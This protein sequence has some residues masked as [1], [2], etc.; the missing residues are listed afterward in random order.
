MIRMPT[1][2]MHRSIRRASGFTLIELAIA[3]AVALFLIGGLLTILQNVRSTQTN[4]TGLAQLQ[5]NQRMAMTLI[6]NVVQSAGYF[7]D[8][9]NYTAT[10]AMPAIGTPAMAAAQP[11]TGTYN[12]ASP[13]DSMT[14]RYATLGGDRVI[15]CIGET[16][17]TSPATAKVYVNT[18]KVVLDGAGS[19]QL[20]CNLTG[21]DDSTGGADTPLIKG[22][23]N[24]VVLY[25]VKRNLATDDNT[26]DTYLNASQMTAADWTNVSSAKITLT[27]NN[28]LYDSI[29]PKGQPQWIT[30]TRVIAVMS[31][32]G[33]RT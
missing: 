19:G 22:I 27:F 23:T 12:A 20:V 3:M 4:Q 18:F 6:T 33:V 5:D 17:Q 28:P 15:N 11:I 7:P 13:G 8:P 1:R 31:R 26:V 30:F 14:A 24:L 25:G 32:A 21:G 29:N 10:S 9:T 2:L 16:N